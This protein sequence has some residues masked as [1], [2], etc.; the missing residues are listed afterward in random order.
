MR[1]FAQAFLVARVMYGLLYHRVNRTQMLAL[2]RLLNE[3]KR[4]VTGLPR[5]TRLDA[6]K[7]C[8]KL[9]NLSELV[10]MHIRTQETWLRATN[11]G[12]YT[13][14]LLGYGIHTLPTLPNKTLPRQV[15]ALTDGKP[16]PLNMD[17]TQRVRRL[18]CDKRHAKAT[19]SLPLTGRIVYTDAALPVDDTSSSCYATACYDQTSGCQNRRHQVSTEA[20]Y[21]TRAELMAIIDYLE[22]ALETSSE[23]D[24]VHH[25]VYTDSQAA[26]RACANV[27][28]TDHVLQKIRHQAC[29]L[30]E[31]SHDVSILWVPA[32]CGIPGNETAHILAR[33][34]LY[35]ALARAQDTPFPL[36]A[37]PR[38]LA[39]P[40]AD[41]Y[42]TKQQRAAYLTAVGNPLLF[43]KIFTRRES[44]LL[45]RIQTG[46][47]LTPV[48]LNRFHRG[49]T[50]PPV[51]GTCSTCNCRADLNH[52]CWECPL[53]IPARLRALATI[54]RGPWPS[55]LLTRA[56]LDPK[57]P[58]RATELWR[59]LLLFLQYPAA[60]PVGD[61][62][63]DSHKIQ[64]APTQLPPMR[65]LKKWTQP[66]P[67]FLL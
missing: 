45:R 22:W 66:N 63:L 37:T 47:L 14:M 18:A 21:S 61:R 54:K 59:A 57:P 30:G 33:A 50:P 16:L 55:S 11:A 56:C 36:L 65:P 10:D 48:L 49:D 23:T 5:Y 7:S 32:H 12:R 29:L 43:T 53:Y 28:Y 25:R 6:L 15:T 31:R 19:S 51:T 39:D 17:P 35:T 38:E 1:Q 52:L 3:A 44:V 9:N 34:H 41:S 60:A 42:L 64:A 4:I 8:N 40:M 27:L 67:F 2:D 58:D 62:L 20:M 46:S 13:L 26:Y 24:P